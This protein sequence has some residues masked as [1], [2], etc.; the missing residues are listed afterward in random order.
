[1]R[2]KRIII[3]GAGGM[4]KETYQIYRD[5]GRNKF[6]DA[7]VINRYKK[8]SIDIYGIPVN[9]EDFIRTDHLLIAG[10]G[11]PKR[12]D[13]IED[14]ELREFLFDTVVDPRSKVGSNV[15][16]GTGSI[17]C[18]NSI[19]TCDLKVGKHVIININTSVHHNSQIGDFTTIGPGCSITGYVNVGSE[20]FIGAGTTIVPGVKIGKKCFI[21]AGSTVTKNIPDFYLAYG[22]PARPI[23]KLV[24]SDWN[25][26]I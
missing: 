12:K 11:T 17:I 20:T 5:L 18:A 4:A 21:G 19:L 22:S 2:R 7:F 6:V 13:W 25:K 3:L 23:R 10:I 1:M 15:E 24:N 14:L 8:N 16:I 26:L 9:G